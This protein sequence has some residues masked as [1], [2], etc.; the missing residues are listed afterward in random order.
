[1]SPE[2]IE[3]NQDMPGF[4][5]FNGTWSYIGDKNIIVD[6]GPAHSVKRLIKS[7]RSMGREHVDY[8]LLT[9][10]HIDHAGGLADFLTYYPTAKIICHNKAMEHLAEPTKL[11]KGSLKVLGAIAE[12]YGPPKPLKNECLIPH[13]EASINN[14]E[15]IET[16]GHAPHHLSFRYD[17]YLFAGEAGGN[18]FRIHNQDY[19]RPATP[20]IFFLEELEYI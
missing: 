6:V 4:D 10:I 9:H 11:W 3:I 2:L 8:I 7:L 13:T 17:G 20:P 5:H 18:Y 12:S 16:P 19:L 15:I 1:M 14:L